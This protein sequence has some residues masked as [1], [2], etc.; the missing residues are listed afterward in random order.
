[1]LGDRRVSIYDGGAA[2]IL[3]CPV[4]VDR[5]SEFVRLARRLAD[6]GEVSDLCRAASLHLRTHPSV[7]DDQTSVVEDVMADEAVDEF[8]NGRP[9]LRR[10]Q[11][12]FG[13]R[14]V[15]SM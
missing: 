7:R 12:Q 2:A 5:E 8:L 3:G 10:L 9:E 11:I 14:S 1:G 13:E 15:K 6:Q 4:V